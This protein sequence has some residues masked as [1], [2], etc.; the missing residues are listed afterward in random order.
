[1][2][3][4]WDRL[5]YSVGPL[6]CFAGCG[7]RLP[8]IL[9]MLSFIHSVHSV[10]IHCKDSIPGCTGGNNCPTISDVNTNAQLFSTNSLGSIPKTTNLL[11][12]SLMQHFSRNVMESIVAIACA[13]VG[14]T[15]IDWTAD[16][17]RTSGAV[18]SAAFYGHC[19]Y[20]DASLELNRRMEAATDAVAVQK[21]ASAIE[22]LK[23]R[24]DAMV[25]NAY[26][27]YRFI[28]FKIGAI[29]D[30]PGTVRIGASSSKAS[31]SETSASIRKAKS[32]DEFYQMLHYFILLVATL[33][34]IAHH[35]VSSFVQ[36]VVFDTITLLKEKWEVAQELMLLYFREIEQ[37]TTK[38]LHLGNVFRRGGRDTLLQ[39]ARNNAGSSTFFRP[40]GGNP[41]TW[42]GKF[43]DKSKIACAA[44]NN[45]KEHQASALDDSGTCKYNHRCNQYVDDKGAG[46]MCWA[47][48]PR[49]SC[50]YDAA[51]K[52]DRKKE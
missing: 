15:N 13:P 5:C 9:F 51:H 41:R 38:S 20:E 19:T 46:G 49:C 40:L 11:P 6:R 17:Y 50:T 31:T 44:Y 14:D 4:Q 35:L 22:S 24:T 47:Q 39:E 8:F 21:I 2:V 45:G 7:T 30:R 23:G 1:M 29:F 3:G 37:D 25:H 26:G 34:L 33:G 10:C 16:T 28:Y 43:N 42:N 32:I 48:H 36:D 27:V 52:L 12:A 18:I